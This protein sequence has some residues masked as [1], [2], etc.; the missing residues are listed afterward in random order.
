MPINS[1]WQGLGVGF[2]ASTSTARYTVK[3]AGL[4][5]LLPLLVYIIQIS[6]RAVSPFSGKGLLLPFPSLRKANFRPSRLPLLRVNASIPHAPSNSKI[7][8]HH[9][10][11]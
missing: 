11:G 4:L 7:D 3:T 8:L 2:V 9:F 1:T 6:V 5:P 10:D